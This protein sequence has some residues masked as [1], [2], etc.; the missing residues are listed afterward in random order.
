MLSINFNISAVKGAGALKPIAPITP[1]G[2]F[3]DTL[4][5]SKKIAEGLRSFQ[6]QSDEMA[7]LPTP[8]ELLQ[9]ADEAKRDLEEK[10]AVAFSQAGVDTTTP[11]TISV[12]GEG[13]VSVTSPHPDTTQIE[14][15]LNENGALKADVLDTAEKT[16]LASMIKIGDEEKKGGQEQ[17][18]Y[19]VPL[20]VELALEQKQR[21]IAQAFGKMSFNGGT[22]STAVE[23]VTADFSGRR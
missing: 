14:N 9:D 17:N 23:A 22:L 7:S 6:L 2:E 10:L 11:I 8:E 16:S 5:T 19:A 4:S 3:P 20:E 15:I 1:V 18:P 13:E 12:S 21:D